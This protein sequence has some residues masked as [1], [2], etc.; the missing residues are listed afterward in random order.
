[1]FAV[2]A[3]PVHLASN[4]AAFWLIKGIDRLDRGVMRVF[5]S[6]GRY[7]WLSMVELGKS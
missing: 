2:V 7:A 1:L 5:P 4:K 3:A 6:L